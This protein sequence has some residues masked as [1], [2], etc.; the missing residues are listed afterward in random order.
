MEEIVFTVFQRAG[1]DLSFWT[2]VL[3]WLALVP[4]VFGATFALTVEWEWDCSW[5]E[6]SAAVEE[7]W[8]PEFEEGLVVSDTAIM[9]AAWGDPY[10]NNPTG[11]L[12]ERLW[13][14][15]DRWL[16][17]GQLIKLVV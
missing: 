7:G 5:E 9:L 2:T 11:G 13:D 12:W 6:I 1:E 14:D 3:T 10:D 16:D 4:A 15:S 8:E 17:K